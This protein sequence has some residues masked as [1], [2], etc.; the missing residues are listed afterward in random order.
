MATKKKTKKRTTPDGKK[1]A[2]VYL[3][4][5]ELA[6]YKGRADELGLTLSRYFAHLARRD[7]LGEN[8]DLRLYTST[9]ELLDRLNKARLNL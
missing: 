3:D 6:L 4:E 7:M 1:L 2:T 8:K 5:E 9:E